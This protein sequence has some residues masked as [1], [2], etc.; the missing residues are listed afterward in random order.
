MA[1]SSSAKECYCFLFTY[2]IFAIIAIGNVACVLR[3]VLV[4]SAIGTCILVLDFSGWPAV[5]LQGCMM[6]KSQ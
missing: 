1:T 3:S 6:L 2:F 4:R 5:H